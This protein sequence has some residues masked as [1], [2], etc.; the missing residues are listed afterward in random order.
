MVHSAAMHHQH[1]LAAMRGGAP[2]YL[3][4]APPVMPQMALQVCAPPPLPTVTRP[5]T[6]VVYSAVPTTPYSPGGGTTAH[7]VLTSHNKPVPTPYS[8]AGGTRA[9]SVLTPHNKPVPTPYSPAGGTAAHSVL[10]PHNKPVPT[11]Y[12][13]AGGTIAHSVLTPH[14]KPVPTPYSP[15]GGTTAHSVLTTPQQTGAHPI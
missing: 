3:A 4:M 13:P 1:H 5:I 6:G 10:T 12:S 7:S 8:P 9:H 14:N 11:P 2:G 15:A